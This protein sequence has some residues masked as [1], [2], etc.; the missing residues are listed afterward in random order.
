MI[1]YLERFIHDNDNIEFMT[2]P[3]AVNQYDAVSSLFNGIDLHGSVDEFTPAAAAKDFGGLQSSN[4]PASS[5]DVAKVLKLASRS[6]H[7]TVA[8]RGN[9]HSVNGQAMA[10]RGLG[11]RHEIDGARNPRGP[12]GGGC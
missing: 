8:A 4:P 6:P 12:K 11:H 10:H 9:G 2:E 7:L 5:D 3:D 1:A